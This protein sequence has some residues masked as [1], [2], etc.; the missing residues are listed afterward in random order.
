ME[1]LAIAIKSH[2]TIH[3]I[4]TEALEHLIALY[5]D[6]AIVFLSVLEKSIPSHLKLIGLFGNFSGFKVNKD[7]S[8]IM[9]LIE[10]ERL[11]PKVSHPFVNALNGLDYLGIKISLLSSANYEVLMAKLSKDTTRW[12]TL[13]LSL[14]GKINMIN[15]LPKFF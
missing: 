5:A 6:D 2:P 10:Q 9:F 14:M 13:P 15:I 8:S 3:G 12:M 11:N 7:K 4:F 1:P